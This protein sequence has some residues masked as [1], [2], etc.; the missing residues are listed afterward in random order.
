MATGGGGGG[1][2]G[3]DEADLYIRQISEE[4][5]AEQGAVLLQRFIVERF[6]R[7]GIENAPTLAD[8]R[9]TDQESEHDRVWVEVGS[10][11]RE[12]G[13]ALD[14]D[15]E[16]QRMINSVPEE[17]TIDNIIAVAHVIFSDG[18]I[19]W[20]RVIGLFYFAYQ[21]CA[22]A[23]GRF[24]DENFPAW[25]NTLIKEVVQL[26]VRKFAQWIINRGGWTSIRE[27]V[28]S[29]TWIWGSLVALSG[30]CLLF[31]IYKLQK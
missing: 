10:L 6:Q 31:G 9:G 11:I 26:L 16:L 30:F 24:I 28:G 12:I 8:I 27:I 15:Q 2:G 23:I 21:M 17:S 1:G 4:D 20:G 29:P 3:Q 14:R 25:V 7:D 19:N 13:D 22:R 18:E 5:I